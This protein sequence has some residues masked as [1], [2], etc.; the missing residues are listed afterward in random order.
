MKKLTI[1]F[2][3]N[4][5]LYNGYIKIISE[6]E[7]KFHCV[8]RR[9][10]VYKATTKINGINVDILFCSGPTKDKSYISSKKHL[11]TKWKEIKPPAADE[12]VK[13]IQNTNKIL[14]L[15]FCGGF[16]GKKGDVHTPEE[17]KE[18]FFKHTYIK[19]K[20]IITAKPKNPIKIKNFLTNKI[21]GEKSRVLTSNIMLVP[22]NIEDRVEDQLIKL[23]S[24]LSKDNDVVEMET[25]P[26][27]KHFKNKTHLGIILMT[28]DLVHIKKHMLRH[29]KFRPSR[30]TF[31]KN[32]IKAIKIA[33]EI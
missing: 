19:H 6:I 2:E 13:K 7:E 26:I 12:I 21:K 4:F 22:N 9:I 16:K 10:S 32:A 5:G 29:D 28:S 18:I 30:K 1:L 27:V 20:E 31:N 25:Y 17:F 3:G 11:E 14:F 24:K 23:A 15:G 8:I 33:L